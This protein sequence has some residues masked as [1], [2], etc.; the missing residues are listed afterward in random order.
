V[1]KYKQNHTASVSKKRTVV[2]VTEH[3]CS[4]L[5]RKG[6]DTDN[7]TI[8]IWEVLE[9]YGH[10]PLVLERY[11]QRWSSFGNVRMEM[12]SVV[13]LLTDRRVVSKRFGQR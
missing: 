11:G 3:N 4:F 2:L 10:R 6:M 12:N 13:K 9:S 8:N 5:I 7:T 1:P